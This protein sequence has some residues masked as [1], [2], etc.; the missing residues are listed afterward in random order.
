[1]R[2]FSQSQTLRLVVIAP[3]SLHPDGREVGGLANLLS[4]HCDLSNPQHR[5]EVA[6]L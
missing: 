2:L 1:M 3:D 4:A 5:A 6:A